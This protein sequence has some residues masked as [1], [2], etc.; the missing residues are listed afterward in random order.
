[1]QAYLQDMEQRQVGFLFLRPYMA[2]SVHGRAYSECGV[3]GCARVGQ[4]RV[5]DQLVLEFGN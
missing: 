4:E 3:N 2:M 5:D 1:M